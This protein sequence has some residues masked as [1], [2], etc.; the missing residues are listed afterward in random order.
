MNSTTSHCRFLQ[1]G[2]DQLVHACGSE[3]WG[4]PQPVEPTPSVPKLPGVGDQDVALQKLPVR[5]ILD[6]AGLVG[7]AITSAS[8][9]S[10]PSNIPRIIIQPG[11]CH[12]CFEDGATHS[13]CFDLSYM[14]TGLT[15][16]LA[17]R[18]SSSR[19]SV[20]RCMMPAR[21]HSRHDDM[22]VG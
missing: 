21:L 8:G 19:L 14:G 17:T 10:R 7:A 4:V 18:N 22:R 9:T 6:R 1:R 2:Y 13:G 3:T 16:H 11:V 15:L 20:S 5:F 12:V